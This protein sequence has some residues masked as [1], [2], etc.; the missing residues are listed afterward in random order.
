MFICGQCTINSSN[1][2]F[3]SDLVIC[4]YGGRLVGGRGLVEGGGC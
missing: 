3:L 1:P 4:V 2:E